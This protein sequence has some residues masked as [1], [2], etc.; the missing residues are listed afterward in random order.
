MKGI[1]EIK[2]WY[3]KNDD[4]RERRHHYKEFWNIIDFYRKQKELEDANSDVFCYR[5]KV[6]LAIEDGEKRL[7]I[8][9]FDRRLKKNHRGDWL[10]SFDEKTTC[11]KKCDHD[12]EKAGFTKKA[13]NTVMILFCKKCGKT[14]E[15]RI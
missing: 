9:S 11:D 5:Y 8:D 1:I 2:L 13:F 6:I 4:S 3:T 15:E 10:E 7:Q 12:W 14:K